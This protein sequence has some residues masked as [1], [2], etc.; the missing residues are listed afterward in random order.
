MLISQIGQIG[1]WQDH[2]RRVAA[3]ID[4]ESPFQ[5]TVA[6]GDHRSDLDN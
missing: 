2:Q 1:R 3:P 6:M 5:L 4:P